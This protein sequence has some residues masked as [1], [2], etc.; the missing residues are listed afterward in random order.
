MARWSYS[1]LAHYKRCPQQYKFDRIEK[2]PKA[3][4][5]TKQKFIGVLLERLV[6]EFFLQRWW[7]QPATMIPAMVS[8][9]PRLSGEVSRAEQ[10]P[11]LRGEDSKWEQ[12]AR[13][14]IGPILRVIRDHR[15]LDYDP[16][17]EQELRVEI[18]GGH[19]VFG[20]ADFIF[21][22]KSGDVAM[23]LDGKGGG[24]IGKGVHGDQL[25]TYAL[26]TSQSP[27][28]GRRVPQRLG[29]WWYR[30]GKIVWKGMDT[31]LLSKFE[32]GVLGTIRQVMANAYPPRP[33]PHCRYCDFKPDCPEGRA[34]LMKR[35]A[36][37]TKLAT[38]QN[39]GV[40]SLSD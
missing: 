6:Q 1:Q 22:A 31:T 16:V 30:H 11:W 37:S 29:F 14:A 9:I 15:L 36:K 32:H 33:G 21:R 38:D 4:F 2:R 39:F 27:T 25:R 10:I 8:A 17:M 23:I 7:A 13:D 3:P 24:N 28:F 12:V 35:A 26:G 34:Y 20:R 18:P 5:D 40:V 19:Q